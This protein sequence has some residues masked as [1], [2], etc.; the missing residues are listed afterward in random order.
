MADS[1]NTKTLVIEPEILDIIAEVDEFKWQG[2]GNVVF[3]APTSLPQTR[4]GK[5]MR[6]PWGA[7]GEGWEW[8]HVPPKGVGKDGCHPGETMGGRNVGPLF[9]S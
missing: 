7:D 9:P 6:A 8:R 4:S 3:T 5:T 2:K 1:L